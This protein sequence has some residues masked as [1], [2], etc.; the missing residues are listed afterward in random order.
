MKP[1]IKECILDELLRERVGGGGWRGLSHDQLATRLNAN[2]PSVRRACRQLPMD[3]RI[4]YA[5]YEPVTVAYGRYE[6]L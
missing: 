5:Q 3:D 1:T 4:H 2:E 6:R